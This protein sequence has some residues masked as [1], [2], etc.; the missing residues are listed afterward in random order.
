MSATFLRPEARIGVGIVMLFLGGLFLEIGPAVLW[1]I[2]GRLGRF[3]GRRQLRQALVR[4][5]R[6]VGDRINCW[7][8][9]WAGG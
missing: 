4:F 3:G 1:E 5:R 2:L 7:R 8:V 6:S 9:R